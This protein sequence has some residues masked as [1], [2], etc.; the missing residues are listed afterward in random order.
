MT[1]QHKQELVD[2]CKTA[3]DKVADYRVGI[4]ML[5]N[6]KIT[7]IDS[8]TPKEVKDKIAEI[9]TKIDLLTADIERWQEV[10]R[11]TVI[12]VEDTIKGNGIM[13]TYN[14]GRTTWDSKGLEG[15]AV[16]HPE[17]LKFRTLGKPSVSI[18]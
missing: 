2:Q 14:K 8:I 16:A 10:I 4:Q 17:I 13:A 15:Y 7:L 6:D 18:R 12:E 5:T 11:E 1:E 9:N 3:L